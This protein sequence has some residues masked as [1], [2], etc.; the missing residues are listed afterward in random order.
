[1]DVF[2]ALL[3]EHFGPLV[4][5]LLG[6][7]FTT[8]ATLA[9]NALRKYIG[10]QSTAAVVDLLH[11]ALESGV[12]SQMAD[13]ETNSGAIAQAAVEYAEKSIPDTM[14]KLKPDY[15]VMIDIAKSKI[16]NVLASGA[17]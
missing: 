1:M 12:K 8:V 7:L 5:Q 17:K 15:G 16:I 9:A 6:I 13:G 10:D 4:L 2:L 11:K 14:A 3:Q